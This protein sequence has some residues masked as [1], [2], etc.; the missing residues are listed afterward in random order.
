MQLR[1]RLYRISPIAP[2]STL[3]LLT[4][5]RP[6]SRVLAAHGWA[7]RETQYLSRSLSFP[8]SRDLMGL[9][10]PRQLYDDIL[11]SRA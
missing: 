5:P 6:S 1:R 10:V 2:A 8:E 4:R 11:S 9:E 7:R 3:A